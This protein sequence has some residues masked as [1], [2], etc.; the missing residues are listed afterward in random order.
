MLLIIDAEVHSTLFLRAH[1]DALITLMFT[2][3]PNILIASFVIIEYSNFIHEVN[4][5]LYVPD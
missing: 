1:K 5:N 3:V 2:F 4:S